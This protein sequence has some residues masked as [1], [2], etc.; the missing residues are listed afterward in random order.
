VG[1]CWTLIKKV[2]YEYMQLGYVDNRIVNNEQQATVLNSTGPV[3][4]TNYIFIGLDSWI[5]H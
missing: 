5:V 4:T 2:R 3:Q 1:Q